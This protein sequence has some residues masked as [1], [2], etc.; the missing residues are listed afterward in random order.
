MTI[1]SV[2]C[3]ETTEDKKMLYEALYARKIKYRNHFHHFFHV[4]AEDRHEKRI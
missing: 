1:C 3:N 4:W 2:I